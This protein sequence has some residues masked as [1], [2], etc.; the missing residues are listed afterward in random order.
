[1]H[2]QSDTN[3]ADDRHFFVEAIN[4][5]VH[6]AMLNHNTTFLNTFYNTMKGVFHGFPLNQVGLAHYNIPHS[7]TQRTNQASTSHQEAALAKSDDAQAIQNLSKQ[8]QGAT[9]NQMQYNPG[10]SVQHVQ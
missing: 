8:I 4:K 6:V 1:M 5:S 7:S 2:G 9:T 3:E 10:S